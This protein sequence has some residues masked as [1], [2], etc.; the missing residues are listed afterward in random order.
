MLT[1]SPTKTTNLYN[2]SLINKYNTKPLL[3]KSEES[4]ECSINSSVYFKGENNKLIIRPPSNKETIKKIDSVYDK[5]KKQLGETS[6]ESIH[7]S[8]DTLEETTEFSREEI[9]NGMQQITQFGNIGSL[10]AIEKSLKENKIGMIANNDQDFSEINFFQAL[11]DNTGLNNTLSYLIDNKKLGQLKGSNIAIFLDKKKLDD[12]EEAK[13]RDE[14]T[15][16]YLIKKPYYKFFLVSG[17]ENGISFLNRSKDL[18]EETKKILIK[19]KEFNLPIEETINK[20]YLDRANKLGISP[21]IIQNKQEATIDNIYKQLKPEQITKKDFYNIIDAT[22]IYR[23]QNIENQINNKYIIADYLDKKLNIYT[24]ERIS[25]CLQDTHSK[26]KQIVETQDKTMDDV[27]YIIP[28]TAKSYDLINYQYKLINNIPDKQIY[29]FESYNDL[30]NFN[31]Q[32]KIMVILDDCSLSGMSLLQDSDINYT[33]LMTRTNSNIILAPIVISEEAEQKIKKQIECG[34]RTHKDF[35]IIN[36]K[37][38]SQDI[39]PR[40]LELLGALIKDCSYSVIFPYM[41]PDNNT[42]F[43]GLVGYYNSIFKNKTEKDWQSI[44][45]NNIKSLNLDSKHIINIISKLNKQESKVNNE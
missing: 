6:I 4:Y 38:T 11:T 14:K 27:L 37:V 13:A 8:V 24:P 1:L 23:S 15:F 22:V 5:Y 7:S 26:I 42:E 17:I 21:I 34:N 31:F 44:V 25:K 18:K 20:D 29:S 19:S 40:Y 10:F 2:Y 39:E 32:D 16:D 28:H 35:L 3:Q 9:L 36:Q 43:G 45:A 30:D 41:C 12:L 33:D